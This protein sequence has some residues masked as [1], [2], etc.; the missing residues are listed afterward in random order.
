MDTTWFAVDRDGNVGIFESGE[1]G[2]VP[3]DALA[4]EG[5]QLYQHLRSGAWAYQP[6]QE[7]L[8]ETL[9]SLHCGVTHMRDPLEDVVMFLANPELVSEDLRA[10]RAREV[11]SAEGAAVFWSRL[12][13]VRYE[14]L[15]AGGACRHCRNDW[16]FEDGGE[17]LRL[18]GS[19]FR[20][21]HLTDNWCAG[22]YTLET[23][24]EQPLKLYQLPPGLQRALS[25]V[26]FQDLSFREAPLVQ[27][28]EQFECE[29]WSCAWIST[30]GTEVRAIPGKEDEYEA[31]YVEWLQDPDDRDYEMRP[32]PGWT[33]K[34]EIT[35]L[36]KRDAARTPKPPP[37]ARGIAGF[38]R[39]LFGG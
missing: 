2:A 18:R 24:P 27:P 7:A 21:E 13:L 4:D 25:H 32:P 29:A 12:S 9:Q 19:L 33:E 20:F 26:Q 8:P 36:A 37:P 11:P 15:H 16:S 35:A 10:G 34:K 5:E 1:S 22:P 23:Q 3:I 38:I 6:A 39:R 14:A 17:N 28:V 31:V 30:D